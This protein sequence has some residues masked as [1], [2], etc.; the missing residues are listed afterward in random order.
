[1]TE[2]KPSTP[3]LTK[4]RSSFVSKVK[5]HPKILALVGLFLV[6]FLVGVSLA[7]V[8]STKKS[9]ENRSQASVTVQSS[10]KLKW[11]ANSSGPILRSIN[12]PANSMV[13]VQNKYMVVATENLPLY[14][15]SDNNVLALSVDIIYN[16]QKSYVK[17]EPTV[18]GDIVGQAK[19][20]INAGNGLRKIHLVIAKK[21]NTGGTIPNGMQIAKATVWAQKQN[22]DE[23]DPSFN[24]VLSNFKVVTPQGVS[25]NIASNL[26]SKTIAFAPNTT[27]LHTQG[28]PTVR[29]TITLTPVHNATITP[30]PT[31]TP[32]ATPTQPAR[33]ACD[34]PAKV[35]SIRRDTNNQKF[36]WTKPRGCTSNDP[37]YYWW[38]VTDDQATDVNGDGQVDY[39]DK[40]VTSSWKDNAPNTTPHTPSNL[41]QNRS[42]HTL[43]LYVFAAGSSKENAVSWQGLTDKSVVQSSHLLCP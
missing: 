8:Q 26:E 5:K 1:M 4:N 16:P 18:S 35:A 13:P 2:N 36:S 12:Y 42:G 33:S 43:K 28:E 25:G 32:S 29:P 37:V 27:P 19:N 6:M 3:A 30:P 17:I 38:Q 41:C 40:L 34:L 39:S 21:P 20:Y 11:A 7:L 15:Y 31:R 22:T 23:A 24:V 14:L 10:A 9:T